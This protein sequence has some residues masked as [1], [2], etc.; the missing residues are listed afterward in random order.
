MAWLGAFG[1]APGTLGDMDGAVPLA[2]RRAELETRR[3]Q[4]RA[5][6]DGGA[7]VRFE[8]AAAC[9]EPALTALGLT[10]LGPLYGSPLSA[11]VLRRV[12]TRD[13]VLAVLKLAG[14]GD[15]GEAT[16]LAAW[17]A[18]G[19]NAVPLL[20]YGLGRWVPQVV[21]L[22]LAA[23]DGGPL[24][25]SEMAAW[26]T[27]VVVTLA[28]AHLPAPTGVRPLAEMLAPRLG[29]ASQVWEQAGLGT[30]PNILDRVSRSG[31]ATLLHGDPVGMNLLVGRDRVWLL[32]P[33]G[34]E[35][36]AE[37]DAGRWVA[38]SLAVAGPTALAPL[39]DTALRADPALR[40]EVLALC[41]AVELVLEVRHRVT[42]PRMF[43]S[44]GA[45]ADTF[46]AD[47]RALV[48]AARELAS[49]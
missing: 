39:L 35:G 1:A 20:D 27:P 7:L 48:D 12:R 23:V 44:L 19:V 34:V 26:T 46:D 24:P 25:H 31:D 8:R 38:R 49:T 4:L 41:A 6:A 45:A 2:R 16:T 11:N 43:V 42:S 29:A 5:V 22:L 18:A 30:P 40:P 13:G 15:V 10:D 32:D 3:A 21:H 36:P 9:V 14:N 37:F 28:S 17:T 47:T 33:A